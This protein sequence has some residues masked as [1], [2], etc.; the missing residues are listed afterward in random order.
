M[1]NDSGYSNLQNTARKTFCTLE[2]D[3]SH[4]VST[5]EGDGGD[6][7]TDDAVG[8]AGGCKH[9]DHSGNKTEQESP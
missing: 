9:P 2:L 7:C 5:S 4:V 3:N 6:D 1:K 8:N